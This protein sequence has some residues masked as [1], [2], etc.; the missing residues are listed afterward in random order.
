MIPRDE[1][2][3]LRPAAVVCVEVHETTAADEWQEPRL[4]SAPLLLLGERSHPDANVPDECNRRKAIL[5][6]RCLPHR[7]N[8]VDG[9][10]PAA[11]HVE[12]AKLAGAAPLN[13]L[14]ARRHG[15]REP[16]GA[17]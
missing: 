4:V 16:T 2:H 17:R 5:P 1:P 11:A 13:E 7:S 3:R 15:E 12:D 10:A 8:R 14:Q 9:V 6:R